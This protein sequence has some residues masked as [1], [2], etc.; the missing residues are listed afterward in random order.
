MF[1]MIEEGEL[2]ALKISQPG[3]EPEEVFHYKPGKYF[4]ELAL[5][6]DQPRAASILCKTDCV[7][8]TLDR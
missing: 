2:V 4:G 3:A 6:K 5:M 7:L 8:A 1:F